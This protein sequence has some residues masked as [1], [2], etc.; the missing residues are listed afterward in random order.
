M[1]SMP[2]GTGEWEGL[3]LKVGA[4]FAPGMLTR[5]CG[6]RIVVA[7]GDPPDRM[8]SVL[9][10]A[11]R[12][13]AA[14]LRPERRRRDYARGRLAA[15]E[16]I[17]LLGEGAAGPRLEVLTGSRGQPTVHGARAGVRVSVS[18]A[19]GLAAACAWTSAEFSMGIDLERRRPTD[20]GDSAY[21][22]T[23]RERERLR[24]HADRALAGLVGW[25]VKEAAFK[26]LV[27]GAGSGPEALE[28]VAFDPRRGRGAVR[29]AGP[30]GRIAHV[31]VGRLHAAGAEY[32]MAVAWAAQNW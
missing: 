27:L 7:G 17:R 22:F 15:R 2:A 31:R 10:E 3:G 8:L 13:R 5:R 23:R 28:I 9:G 11:E 29:A 20:V 12:R 16:A 32:V 24:G 30:A 25:T 21:A 6:A 19:R 18:H 4:A 1:S 14:S 26:A